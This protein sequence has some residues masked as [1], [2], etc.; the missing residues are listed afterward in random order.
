MKPKMICGVHW[1]EAIRY[2]IQREAEKERKMTE[3]IIRSIRV[4]TFKQSTRYNRKKWTLD[5]STY[6]A[7]LDSVWQGMVENI[8]ETRKQS[9]SVCGRR[10]KST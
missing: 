3:E 2:S 9:L 5:R 10:E 1:F 6:V 7:G 4:M 8:K